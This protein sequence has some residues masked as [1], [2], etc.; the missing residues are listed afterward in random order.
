[1]PVILAH[2]QTQ[3]DIG[4]WVWSIETFTNGI[5]FDAALGAGSTAIAAAHDLGEQLRR[6]HTIEIDAFGDLPP[7]PYPVYPSAR[8]WVQN[9]QRRVATAVTLIGE[10]SVMATT[11]ER[12]YTQLA[13]WYVGSPRLCKGDCASTNLLVDHAQH[14]TLIDWEWAQ[15][16]DPAADVAYWCH[17]TPQHELHEALLA[18]YQPDDLPLFRRRMLAYR[19]V[20]SIELIH[21]YTEHQDAFSTAERSAGLRTEAQALHTLLSVLASFDC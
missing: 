4:L 13:A 11:I 12:I 17:F 20:H 10:T 14:V 18:A 8:A 6:L 5:A 21:I 1:M 16:L 7:R 3:T 2:D 19:V 15:G 9:K